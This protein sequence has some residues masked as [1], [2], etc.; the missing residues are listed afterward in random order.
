MFKI[1]NL[2][3]VENEK[4]NIDYITIRYN[5]SKNGKKLNTKSFKT[6]SFEVLGNI[7]NNNYSL[8]FCLNCKI[9]CLLKIPINKKID[10]NNYLLDNESF[11]NVNGI[12]IIE[13]DMNIKITR[14]FKNKFII[15]ITF[16]NLN[17]TISHNDA[18]YSG[19]IEFEFNLDDYLAN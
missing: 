12:T 5:K 1:A 18:D 14:Y 13:P 17:S 11:L 8:S 16:F 9:E 10:F 2:N 3:I 15:F 19:I 4:I 6:L 7:D